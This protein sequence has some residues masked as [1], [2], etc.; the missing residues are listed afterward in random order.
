MSLPESACRSGYTDAELREILGDRHDAFRH[1]MRGQTM[2]VCNGRLYNHETREY[3]A[4]ECGP[5]GP[6]TY[7][8]DL[9]RFLDGLPV[10]D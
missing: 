2:T 10:I 9:Q 8:H 7:G 5:H 4:S 6:V 3:Y 1:W